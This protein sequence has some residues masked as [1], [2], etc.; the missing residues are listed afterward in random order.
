M[1]NARSNVLGGS[2]ILNSPYS[3][4]II[5]VLFLQHTVIISFNVISRITFL[6][7]TVSAYF[8]TGTEFYSYALRT[9]KCSVI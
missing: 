2:K 8:E 9:V 5:F 4:F 3:A 6:L 1:V 7:E